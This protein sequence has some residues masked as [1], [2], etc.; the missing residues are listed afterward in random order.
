[1]PE[2]TV[3]MNTSYSPFSVAAPIY[4]NDV[5]SITPSNPNYATPIW[6][7]GDSFPSS[8]FNLNFN[9]YGF[10]SSPLGRKTRSGSGTNWYSFCE[11]PNIGYNTG[12]Q[13]NSMTVSIGVLP[14]ES[15]VAFDNTSKVLESRSDCKFLGASG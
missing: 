9:A 12:S 1:M 2:N 13:V 8:A 15:I 10:A 5:I 6:S 4:K 3:Q 7:I 14:G 11:V